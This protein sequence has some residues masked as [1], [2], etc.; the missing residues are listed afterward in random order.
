MVLSA[1]IINL[2]G[3]KKNYTIKVPAHMMD[4]IVRPL[5]HKRVIAS[6]Q[7][8]PKGRGESRTLVHCDEIADEQ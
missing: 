4:D 5:W 2:T 8:R 7:V 3:D 1:E 6:V